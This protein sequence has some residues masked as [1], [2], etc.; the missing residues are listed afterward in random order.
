MA[1]TLP[2]WYVSFWLVVG[3]GIFGALVTGVLVTWA[4]LYRIL[5]AIEHDKRD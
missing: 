3:G 2:D 4:L 5:R 1:P